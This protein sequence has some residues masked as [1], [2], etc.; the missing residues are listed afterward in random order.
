MWR[1]VKRRRYRP[2]TRALTIG[3]ETL[4]LSSQRAGRAAWGRGRGR[5]ARSRVERVAGQAHARQGARR[6]HAGESPR[7]AA[8][9]AVAESPAEEPRAAPPPATPVPWRRGGPRALS[10]PRS[11]RWPRARTPRAAA[12]A[13]RAAAAPAAAAP[14]HAEVSACGRARAG[15]PLRSRA[16]PPSS[17]LLPRARG[18]GPRG[19]G[20][21][22]GA[23]SAPGVRSVR[24][25]R[26]RPH[27]RD[28]LRGGGYG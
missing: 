7:G 13:A 5:A 6:R 8:G 23:A 11:A 16:P 3:S 14:R 1:W 27:L 22:G 2:L 25:G 24:P 4:S 15:R 21:A 26:R 10:V 12:R 20:L 28:P 17:R 19:P 9:G 18:G